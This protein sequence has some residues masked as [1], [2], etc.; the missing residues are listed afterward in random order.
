MAGALLTGGGSGVSTDEAVTSFHQ[1]GRRVPKLDAWEKVCGQTQYIHDLKLPGMLYGKIL[2][3]RYPHARIKHIDT[4][5][6]ERLPGVKAVVTGYNTPEIKIGF[7]KD[8]PVLKK[9]KVRQYRDEVAAVAATSP[10]IAEEALELIQVEYEELPAVFDPVEAMEEGAP[11]IHE[12][13]GTNVLPLPWRLTVGDV[14]AARKE[15][16][17][18]VEDTFR[19]SWVNH[20]CLGT[21]GCVAQFH[22]DGNLTVYSPTQIRYLAQRD[23]QTALEALGLVGKRVRVV[24]VAA[25]GAFGGKLDTYPYEFIAILLAYYTGRPVK[26]LFTREE[27][28]FATPARQPAIIKI[29]QGCTRDGRL[30]FR[31]VEMILDNGAYT[32]WGATTPSVMMMPTSSLYK[33]P[34]V[35]F[36]ATCVYTNNIYTTAMRGYGNPQ[37]T[38][39]I[40]SQLDALAEEAGIDPADFRMIN[41][42]APGETTP[43]GFKVTSCGLKECLA[44]VRQGLDWEA[45][46]GRRNGRGVGMASLIHVGGGAR[47][48]RSDG[49]GA[50]LK[51][52]DFGKVTVLTGATDMGQGSETVIAQIVAEE[53]GVEV[54]DVAVVNNNTDLETWDVGAHASRTTFVAGNAALKAARKAKE[55]ILT[56][57]S[58]F[59]GRE[60]EDLY[61]TDRHVCSRSRPDLRVPLAKLIRQAHFTTGGQMIVA[62]YFYDPPTEMLGRDMR[63]NFSAAYTYGTHGVEVEVDRET[64][65]VEIK[66]YIFAIDAGRAVN[67][68]LLEGQLEGGVAM[69]L[70]YAL[71]EEL[72]LEKGKVLNPNFL[73]YRLP[74]SR[75]VPRVQSIIVETHDPEGPFGA[76]GVGEP[77]LVAVAPAVANAIYDAVGVRI[78]ELPI[79]PEK[80]LAALKAA[81]CGGGKPWTSP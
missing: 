12:E 60:K 72:K 29:V 11:L 50:I 56:L 23:F 69:G 8:N 6:A 62:D 76:K 20:C 68:M 10:D 80:I 42:N 55:Q 63:G 65:Q 64:G 2:Y 79:T 38:F 16:A 9:D 41:A 33:V 59:L 19:V 14:E 3:S 32:S 40:E 51:I 30:T 22:P 47:I 78:K 77:P 81:P 52:D 58:W 25:G 13:K 18:V 44:A 35:R 21:S 1:V 53:L 17:F 45:K 54:E 71:T 37:I 57:A 73:D 7:L 34:N 67:P 74:T 46:R 66:K 36:A 28:F 61:L 15:S 48:Y 4:S 43:Q 27:E 5:R 70:G 31:D 24:R 26:M 39:A 49:C 75:D